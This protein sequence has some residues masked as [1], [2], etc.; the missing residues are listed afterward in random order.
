M[1][2]VKPM[3]RVVVIEGDR[4]TLPREF[5]R[6]AKI[7]RGDVLEYKVQGDSLVLSRRAKIENPTKR[8]FGIA[9]GVSGDMSGDELLLQETRAKLRR[10]K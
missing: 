7:R 5:R 8:I 2:Y 1:L 10:S 4:V 9:S 6:E 3:G